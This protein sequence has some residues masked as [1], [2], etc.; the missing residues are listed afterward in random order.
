VKVDVSST[1]KIKVGAVEMGH[2]TMYD[3]MATDNSF[4]YRSNKQSG[5]STDTVS[6]IINKT[7]WGDNHEN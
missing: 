7:F 5:Y 2:G 6:E 1:G 3:N 4:V